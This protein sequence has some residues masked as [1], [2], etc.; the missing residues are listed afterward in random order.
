MKRLILVF[1]CLTLTTV[2]ALAEDFHLVQT[3]IYDGL[4]VPYEG[5]ATNCIYVLLLP[6]HN[7][8]GYVYINPVVLRKFNGKK[9]GKIIEEAVSRGSLPSGSVLRFDPSPVMERPPD[10]EVKELK[11]YCKKIGVTVVVSSTA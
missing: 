10:A 8:S 3:A 5:S 7:P 9:L 4:P 6:A 1:S 2:A 11:D